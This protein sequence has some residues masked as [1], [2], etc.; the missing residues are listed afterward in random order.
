MMPFFCLTLLSTFF[1]L[2][3]NFLSVTEVVSILQR[4]F[5]E[6]SYECNATEMP[7]HLM[8]IQKKKKKTNMTV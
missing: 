1:C 6:N 4:L 7:Q 5:F 3:L 2:H 8:Q